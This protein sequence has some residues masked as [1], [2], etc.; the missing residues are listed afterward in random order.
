MRKIK[1]LPNL[2]LCQGFFCS[3]PYMG[4]F[5]DLHNNDE[6]LSCLHYRLKNR[7]K[8]PTYVADLDVQLALVNIPRI[9]L[10]VVI[11]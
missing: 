4:S 8:E 10:V 1:T 7:Q 2:H 9:Q 11:L 5:R 3:Y 6:A